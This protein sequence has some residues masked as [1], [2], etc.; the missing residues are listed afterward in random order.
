MKTEA[1]GKEQDTSKSISSPSSLGDPYLDRMLIDYP[2]YDYNYPCPQF[3]TP[4][5]NQDIFKLYDVPVGGTA[6]TGISPSGGDGNVLLDYKR[7]LK[8]T[9][10]VIMEELLA[11]IP[12]AVSSSTSTIPITAKNAT[13]AEARRTREYVTE[14]IELVAEEADL[15]KDEGNLKFNRLDTKRIV[16]SREEQLFQEKLRMDREKEMG[17]KPSSMMSDKD[18]E[19]QEQY[20][21]EM[22]KSRLRNKFKSDKPSL[23]DTWNE[24]M[25]QSVLAKE[26]DSI[27][28]SETGGSTPTGDL[29][30]SVL[31]VP[32]MLK[33]LKPGESRWASGIT[34][35][36]PIVTSITCDNDIEVFLTAFERS[37]AHAWVYVYLFKF[38]LASAAV[39]QGVA[40]AVYRMST[41]AIANTK[42]IIDGGDQLSTFKETQKA[43]ADLADDP[44]VLLVDEVLQQLDKDKITDIMQKL[45]DGRELVTRFVYGQ[46]LV[47]GVREHQRGVDLVKLCSKMISARHH[48]TNLTKVHNIPKDHTNNDRY[49]YFTSTEILPNNIGLY[50]DDLIRILPPSLFTTLF[51]NPTSMEDPYI[52][53]TFDASGNVRYHQVI[54]AVASMVNMT[55]GTL[56]SLSPD[57]PP[58]HF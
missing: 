42:V 55:L 38:V 28:A 23:K 7:E 37:R 22:R 35:T 34:N 51:P 31:P 19:R 58:H 32:G 18:R 3:L 33:T 47:N 24:S 12:T 21:H 56:R 30:R 15:K 8:R 17:T 4:A 49:I 2:G 9:L 1:E 27:K 46:Y 44:P 6:L 5:P 39:E 45:N 36:I 54:D 41:N 48:E 29:I 52:F 11:R 43:K 40:K 26:R 25:A 20:E 16:D 50:Q 13:D 53:P 10:R 14:C 57:I